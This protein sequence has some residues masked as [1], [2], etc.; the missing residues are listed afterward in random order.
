M[1]VVQGC[2]VLCVC[3]CVCLFFVH[4]FVVV[5]DSLQVAPNSSD[6]LVSVVVFPS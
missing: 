5:E 3:V 6:L 2:W 4:I 1:S